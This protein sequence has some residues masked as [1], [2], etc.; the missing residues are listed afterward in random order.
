[1]RVHDLLA[2]QGPGTLE[3]LPAWWEDIDDDARWQDS[4]FI[5][6][7]VAYGTLAVVALVQV[8]L[9][10]SYRCLPSLPTFLITGPSLIL[11]LR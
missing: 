8:E 6:L 3:R 5:A 9:F 11:L 4:V 10:F 7:A 1:M 2:Y